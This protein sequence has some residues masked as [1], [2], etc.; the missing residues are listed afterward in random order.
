[1]VEEPNTHD[2]L[3]EELLQPCTNHTDSGRSYMFSNHLVQSVIL[4][5][6]EIPKI[7]TNFE[8]RIG[9]ISAGFPVTKQGF[10]PVKIIRRSEGFYSIIAKNDDGTIDVIN[11]QR[12]VPLT[13]SYGYLQNIVEAEEFEE[14]EHVGPDMCLAAAT[15][16][17]D[18]GNL[19]VGTNLRTV[20]FPYKGLTYED[21][22]VISKSAAKKLAYNMVTEY[23]VPVNTND[24]LINLYG[25]NDTYKAF[26]DIGEEIVDGVLCSRRRIVNSTMLGNLSNNALRKKL[27]TDT[28]IYARGKVMDIFIY[29]NKDISEF[30]DPASEQIKKYLA[31]QIEYD[32]VL[33]STIEKLMEDG[34]KLT[35][36]AAYYYRRSKDSLNDNI[37]WK[38]E[39]AFDNIVIKFT[40]AYEKPALVG[41]KITN[42]YGGKGVVA[43]IVDDTEMPMTEDGRYAEA[44]LNPL[45][46]LG[47]M[48]LST[49]FEQEL[50]FIGDEVRLRYKDADHETKMD[51][52]MEFYQSVNIV[53]QAADIREHYDSLETD[54]ERE[55]F[56]DEFYEKGFVIH[57]PPFFD[58]MNFDW[59]IEL[60]DAFD[61]KPLKFKNIENPLVMGDVYYLRLKHEP[62]SKMS[63]RS[64]G[65]INMKGIPNK[66][67]KIY[68]AGMAPYS[69][70]P[71]RMGEQETLNL[72]LCQNPDAVFDM[73]DFHSSN[74]EDRKNL[75]HKLLTKMEGE[76][77]KLEKS[78]FNTIKDLLTAYFTVLGL[79]LE[80][81][82][83]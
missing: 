75:I 3:A 24:L 52:L 1:V 55:A 64:C 14:I 8:N 27:S 49:L 78:R 43:K 47:R 59:L 26:P 32:K 23:M 7:F 79:Q 13:E 46:I 12:A 16:Y 10:K 29:S 57:Q 36:D 22:L 60:Y 34:S 18:D 42:R 62:A 31:R 83:E 39:N 21:S 67:N 72:L 54:E 70:T 48:N 35:S 81:S 28:S 65:Q 6:P 53:G 4:A 58:N 17:D 73:L 56:I 20:F 66:S 38:A 19:M 50:N 74:K 41:S 44:C 11:Q 77:L 51:R 45:G 71:I 33:T 61:V 68:K 63:A 5:N 40:V 80:P 25:N 69:N 15:C 2:F 37:E 76:P 9:Q 82:D 30:N